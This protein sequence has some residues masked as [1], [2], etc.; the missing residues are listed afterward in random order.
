MCNPLTREH[1]Q[2]RTIDG[3]RGQHDLSSGQ[4]GL[5]QTFPLEFHAVRPFA[6]RVDEHFGHVRPQGYV[7]VSSESDRLQKG[8][9]RTATMTSAH[10]ELVQSVSRLD[11]T[12]S[13]PYLVTHFFASL[14]KRDSC[15]KK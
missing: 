7:Q 3:A 2:L 1:Q 10:R 11:I 6:G 4:R 14:Q 5:L 13:V 15:K 9:R 12:V 8:L